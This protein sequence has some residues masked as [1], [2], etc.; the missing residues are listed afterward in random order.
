[1]SLVAIIA[2]VVI[3]KKGKDKNMAT[4]LKPKPAL[5]EVSQNERQRFNQAVASNRA[6]QNKAVKLDFSQMKEV[7]SE[8]NESK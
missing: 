4:A 7:S 5:F 3:I 2:I 6:Q 8:N 1:M